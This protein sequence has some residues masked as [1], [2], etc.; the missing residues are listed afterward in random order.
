[1]KPTGYLTMTPQEPDEGE[2]YQIPWTAPQ[3]YEKPA[4]PPVKPAR[5]LTPAEEIFE[6][7]KE[8]WKSQG[9]PVPISDAKAC[10]DMIKAEKKEPEPEPERPKTLEEQLGPRPLWGDP[11]FWD[12]WRKAKALGFTNDKK[13]KK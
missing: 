3:V 7:V 12:Y 2:P 8:W 6:E 5:A 10:L 4:A 1:M 9:K 11:L 13:K